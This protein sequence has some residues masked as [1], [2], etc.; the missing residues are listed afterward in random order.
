MDSLGGVD[1]LWTKAFGAE[2]DDCGYG[3][4]ISYSLSSNSSLKSLSTK[5]QRHQVNPSNDLRGHISVYNFALKKS[6]IFL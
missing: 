2:F 3:I 1:I 4:A 6:I 5:Y